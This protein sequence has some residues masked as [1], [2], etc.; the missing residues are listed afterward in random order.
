MSEILSFSIDYY[1]ILEEDDLITLIQ[2]KPVITGGNR[3]NTHFSLEAI[4]NAEPT[5]Y[6]KPVICLWNKNTSD[7]VEH[8]RN[9]KQKEMQDCVGCIPETNKSELIEEDD[10]TAQYIN[11]AIWK[12]YFPNIALK[13]KNNTTTKL[14][15]EISV[16]KSHKRDDGLLEIDEYKYV[17]FTLLGANMLEAIPGATAKIIKYSTTDYSDMVNSTNKQLSQFIVPEL[18]KEN[19]KKALELIPENPQLINFAKDIINNDTLSFS[20]VSW[21]L[22]KIQNLEN[23]NNIIFFGGVESKEWCEDIIQKFNVT[24]L[25]EKEDEIVQK[26]M[27]E[28]VQLK[29][30]LN[31]R[32]VR[33]ILDIAIA[34][35]KYKNG[36]YEYRKYWVEAWDEE[37]VYVEDGENSKTLS[38]K[39]V[40]TENVA[41]IDF[42]S[43]V[44]V[45]NAG[46]M[47][48]GD[49]PVD[50]TDYKSKFEEMSAKF[51]EMSIKYADAEKEKGELTSNYSIL[52]TDME[53]LK[54][55][56]INTEKTNLETKANELYSKYENY[57]T[58]EE[59]QDL[60]V[61]LFSVDNFDTFKEKVFA[62]VTPKMEAENIALK[63]N[64]NNVDPN[65]IQFST[66]PLLNTI[67]KNDNK[68]SFEKLKEYANSK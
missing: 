32:Q 30:G 18:V 19:A 57:I 41:T 62:I 53:T 26:E 40:I 27:H 11:A 29:F 36:D 22:N 13:L 10:K 5:L 65:T 49:K 12:Y 7:F 34:N 9:A 64:K 55:F 51:E 14:S 67:D 6:N 47:P 2:L 31:S 43:A 37:L 68:S 38:M 1:K 33:E 56:K 17:G 25:Q 15:M 58:E 28:K 21:I 3:H 20:K 48:V 23:E 8:A 52:E 42:E 4:K 66:M 45:I 44:E 24:E 61:K 35:I 50:T 60:N 59:K 63:Q 39:Y 16:E 46:Y 54:Q